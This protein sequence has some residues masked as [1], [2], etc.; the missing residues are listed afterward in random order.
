MIKL[1]C[2]YC[3]KEFLRTHRIRK[4][5]KHVFCSK[6]CSDKGMD[7]K[8]TTKMRLILCS[9]CNMPFHRGQWQFNRQKNHFCSRKCHGNWNS[10]HRIANNG[11]NWKGGSYSTI[12]HTLCNSRYR[13]V[14]KLVLHLDNN[15]CVLCQSDV[16]LQSHHIIEKVENPTLIWDIANM[17][18]LCR[19]CHFSIRNREKDYIVF[20]NDIIAK[21]VKTEKPRTGNPVPSLEIANRLKKGVETKVEETIIPNSALPE[22]DDI[23]QALWEHKK[24]CITVYGCTFHD[25]LFGVRMLGSIST[26]RR[27]TISNCL[28]RNQTA[29]SVDTNIRLAGTNGQNIVIDSCT[30]TTPV[31][32]AGAAKMIN[33]VDA[34]TGTISNCNFPIDTTEGTTGITDNGLSQVNNHQ[35]MATA[36]A[37]EVG[38]VA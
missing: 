16:S 31:G 14:R 28:F 6:K 32:T 33:I 3:G 24:A 26:L 36:D 4:G 18:T 35:A 20:F 1:S 21:R 30:F 19:K 13:K 29:A 12:A 2:F 25:C 15:K 11:A 34:M 22:R 9:Y 5:C 17:V 23:V 27:I 7:K 8:P 37:G 10:I 38:L